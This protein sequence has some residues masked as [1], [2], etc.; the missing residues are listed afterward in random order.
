MNVNLGPADLKIRN[1]MIMMATRAVQA[2]GRTFQPGLYAQ[3]ELQL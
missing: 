1:A 2:N 3:G